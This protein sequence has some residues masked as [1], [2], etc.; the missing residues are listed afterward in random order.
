MRHS[1][2]NKPALALDVADGT[3]STNPEKSETDLESSRRDDS[4]LTV[5]IRPAIETINSGENPDVKIWSEIMCGFEYFKERD[6]QIHMGV[7]RSSSIGS[8]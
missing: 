4:G 8:K 1:H 7:G 5:Q 2:S 3:D 6:Q